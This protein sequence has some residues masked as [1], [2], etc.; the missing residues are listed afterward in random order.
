MTLHISYIAPQFV[1]QVS[2]RLVSQFDGS[3]VKPFDEE[4]NKTV[5][6]AA[7]DAYVTIGYTG[8]AY[9]DGR[10]TDQWIAETLIGKKYLPEDR[11]P[12]GGIPQQIWTGGQIYPWFDI[13]TARRVLREALVKST[14]RLPRSHR[15]RFPRLIMA[16]WQRWN[17][18]SRPIACVIA[19]DGNGPLYQHISSSPRYGWVGRRFY[20]NFTPNLAQLGD[21]RAALVQQLEGGHAPDIT[22]NLIARTLHEAADRI[23]GI[24]KDYLAVLLSP[25]GQRRIRSR[26]IA[27]TP[28]DKSVLNPADGKRF[29]VG[30]VGYSP[31]IVTPHFRAG[32][33]ITV[34]SLSL[35][36]TLDGFT[37]EMEQPS[38]Q[39]DRSDDDTVVLSFQSQRRPD[40]P[41]RSF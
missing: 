27:F 35:T 15:L 22:E 23:P 40:W 6:Y 11:G 21:L 26:F 1:L 37:F 33:A 31:W 4:A 8:L 9:L 12:S 13:G 5:F 20:V 38:L 39:E 34:G 10:P 36:G 2:D 19:D 28:G 18:Q 7:R 29:Y 16:G 32:P 41:L 24:G 30:P 25:P 3:H 17:R 14:L